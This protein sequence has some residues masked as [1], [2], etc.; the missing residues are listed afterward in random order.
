MGNEVNQL[1]APYKHARY[2]VT[3]YFLGHKHGQ[4]EYGDE[5]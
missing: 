1:I 3:R 2:I 4:V 5:K